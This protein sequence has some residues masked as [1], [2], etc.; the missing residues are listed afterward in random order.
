M[1]PIPKIMYHSPET[2]EEALTLLIEKENA[3]PLTGGTDL[4]TA[5]KS[6]TI[7]PS[8]LVDLN[9]IP[10]LNYIK[11][12]EKYIKIGATTTHTQIEN[13]E[14]TTKLP[15]LVEAVS[16]IGSPQI[17]NRGTIVGNICNASPAADSA[18]PLLVHEAEV[19]IKSLDEERI[20][21]IEDLFTGPKMNCLEASEIVSE[22][23]IPEPRD[24]SWSSYKKIGRRKAFTLSVVSSA[25]YIE[26]KND[27]CIDAR[28]AFGSV[29]ATPIR[30]PEAEDLLRDSQLDED[31]IEAAS[32][33]V[34]E[35][36]KPIT[37]IR[38]TAEYRKDMCPILMRR[39][40]NQC[41]ENL[42]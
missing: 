32:D 17:R 11:L 23:R 13:N 6:E 41:L 40:V 1:R 28:L 29:A 37:D 15:A 5:M 7:S 18:P 20:I 22:I 25:S 38:G 34:H 8:H 31:T 9:E 14:Y 4:I 21:S 39:A 12:E 42:R 27:I 2:L 26:M 16:R 19:T 10:E 33:I 35:T 24:N 30:V 3:K 36:V